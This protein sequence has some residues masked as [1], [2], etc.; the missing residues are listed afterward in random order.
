LAAERKEI[1]AKIAAADKA[2]D[3]ADAK[4]TEVTVPLHGRLQEIRDAMWA[5]ESAKNDLWLTCED[6]VLKTQ[7]AEVQAS[8]A[9]ARQETADLRRQI[10]DWKAQV[11]SDRVAVEQAKRMLNGEKRVEEARD[12][13][14]Q[15]AE[16]WGVRGCT[17]EGRED[18]RRSGTP[19]GGGSGAN[20]RGVSRPQAGDSRR[21][22]SLGGSVL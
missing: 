1:E 2:L 22:P 15:R 10:D 18:G 13:A 9:A 4:H 6:P 3:E 12:L 14:K 17:G 20:G 16:G 21:H 5:A 8:L 19:G 11:K 7:L